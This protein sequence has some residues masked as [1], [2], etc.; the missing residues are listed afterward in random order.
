MKKRYNVAIVGATGAVGTEMLRVLARRRFPVHRVRLLASER[1]AG[2]RLVFN[3]STHAVE[4]LKPRSFDGI[5]LALFSAGASRS[6]EFAPEAVRRGA[7]V[8]DNSSAFRMAPDV[9]LVVPEVNPGALAGHRGLIANPNCSTIIMVVALAPLHRAAT[10]RRI[11]VSTYQSVSGAGTK[12][13]YQLWQETM[14]L[15]GRSGP[16]ARWP[17]GPFPGR[18]LTGSTGKTGSTVLPQQIAFN[19]IP[20]VDVFLDNRSTR[21]EMKMVHETRKL[22][23]EP[24][25][26]VS[27]TCVRVPVFV[28]H[29]EAVWIETERPLSVEHAKTLLR[30]APGVKLVDD[31]RRGAYPLPIRAAGQDD[32]LVGRIRR[33]ESVERGLALWVSG[34]NLRK[35]AATNAVQIAE[36]LLKR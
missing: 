36:L 35:G 2:R 8:V 5:D 32:V 31:P 4:R 29:S 27:A 20:Q 18:R 3:G 9:P 15:I 34:D 6:L 23:G 7:V 22:L 24:G 16:L 12:A 13:M 26:P 28:A 17:V 10:L 33:D 11:V 1:S 14:Q 30:R 19:V 21:E 25:L